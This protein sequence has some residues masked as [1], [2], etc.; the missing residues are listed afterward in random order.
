MKKLFNIYTPTLLILFALALLSCNSYSYCIKGKVPEDLSLEGEKVYLYDSDS[1]IIDSATINKSTF[2]LKGSY[3]KSKKIFLAHLITAGYYLDVIIEPN[4]KLFAD[5][6]ANF[7]TTGTNLNDQLNVYLQSM[8]SVEETH[9]LDLYN[10]FNNQ[11]ISKAIKVKDIDTIYYS[12]RKEKAKLS[13][14]LLKQHPNDVLGKLALHNALFYTNELT[15]KKFNKLVENVDSSIY[16]DKRVIELINKHNHGIT[17]QPG[18]YYVDFEA[19]SPNGQKAKL[20]DYIVKGRYLM[21]EFWGIWCKPCLAQIY[22]QQQLQHKYEGKNVDMLG[23]LLY[24]QNNDF[25]K[26]FLTSMDLHFPNII[27]IKGEAESKYN[28][29]TLPEVMIIDPYGFIMYRGLRGNMPEK[30]MDEILKDP[31]AHLRAHKTSNKNPVRL[32]NE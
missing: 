7:A 15:Q 23:V 28:I 4:C 9:Y 18:D 29:T 31:D 2:S 26:N 27:D 32:T 1:T 19:V 6:D 5:M 12:M 24:S 13:E 17:T 21:I 14:A 3:P 22:K 11:N 25:V 16:A 8:D 30:L 20:S 10:Y